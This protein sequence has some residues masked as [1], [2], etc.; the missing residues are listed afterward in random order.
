MFR[1]GASG[2]TFRRRSSK[3]SGAPE[4]IPQRNLSMLANRLA[5]SGGRRIPESAL[6]LDYCLA[7]FL[8]GLS[9]TGLCRRV[10]FKGG[11]A[12]KR[13]YFSDYRFSEDLDFTLV[14]PMPPAEILRNL[15]PVYAFVRDATGI[16]FG[17]EHRDRRAHANSYTFYLRYIG[18]LPAARSLKVDVTVRELLV[19][20]LEDR[21]VL[22]GYEEFEDLPD[23]RVVQTYSLAEIASEKAVALIDRARNEPRDLYDLWYLTARERVDLAAVVPA[24]C[25]K[26]AFRKRPAEGL[27]EAILKKEDRLKAVWRVRLA[28]Q[29][30]TLPPFEEVFRELRRELRQ[31][32]LP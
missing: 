24:I 29:M 25:A 23:D 5:N 4:L 8:V 12:L 20:P 26:L 1:A 11:T 31:A 18:P 28:N 3:P 32:Y 2:S 13:C 6:A 9:H 21:P 10:A 7:W 16:Q 14:E 30:A 15:E 19:F 17:F 27:Q 22:R